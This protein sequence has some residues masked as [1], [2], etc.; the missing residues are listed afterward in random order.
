MPDP[1]AREVNEAS[2]GQEAEN[3]RVVG[4]SAYLERQHPDKVRTHILTNVRNDRALRERF[5]AHIAAATSLRSSQQH[6]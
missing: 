1:N 4:G 3:T 5:P 6:Q 2:G